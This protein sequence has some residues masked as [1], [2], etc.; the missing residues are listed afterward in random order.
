MSRPPQTGQAVVIGDSGSDAI[1]PGTGFASD[2][3]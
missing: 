1:G 2:V 3:F